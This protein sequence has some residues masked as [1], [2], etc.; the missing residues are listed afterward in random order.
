MRVLSWRESA[1]FTEVVSYAPPDAW[2]EG[3]RGGLAFRRR[4]PNDDPDG[5]SVVTAAPPRQARRQRPP[6]PRSRIAR[7][8]SFA[9]RDERPV[10][11][12]TVRP[13]G[14]GSLRTAPTVARGYSGL[15]RLISHS[16]TKIEHF[17][18]R[19]RDD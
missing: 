16:V 18:R 8:R 2:V 5:R 13:P 6:A 4:P 10:T 19:L 15:I 11:P 7:L 9:E 14:H 3:R 12:A 17:S 1:R